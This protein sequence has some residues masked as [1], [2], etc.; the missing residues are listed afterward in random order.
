MKYN[1]KG[2]VALEALI[3]FDII[4]IKQE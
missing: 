3:I 2:Q 1:S 4:E